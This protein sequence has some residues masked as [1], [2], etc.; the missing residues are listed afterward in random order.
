MSSRIEAPASYPVAYQAD[1][2]DDY[3]GVLVRD[4]YRWLEDPESPET[5]A[6]VAAQNELTFGLLRQVPVREAIESHLTEIWD[7]PKYGLPWRR[8]KHTFFFKNDGLQNQAVLYWQERQESEPN[9]LLDPNLL[10]EDGTVALTNLS[11]NKE[12]TLIAYGLSSSGSDWQEIRIRD[13]VSGQD[14]E[15][16]LR[17]CKFTGI[18]WKHDN[19]GFF[20]NRYREPG[21]VPPEDQYHHNRVYWHQLGTPQ[22]ADQL[23]YERLDAKELAFNPSIT[24]DG[25]Y[26]VLYVWHGTDTRNRIYYRDVESDQ[27]FVYLLDEQ[28]ARYDFITNIGHTFY[29]NSDLEAP[30]GRIIAIDIRQPEREAWQEIIPQQEDVLSFVHLINQQFVVAYLHHAHHQLKIF[31]LDGSF[32]CEIELPALGSITGLSGRQEDR[33]MFVGLSS[34]LFPNTAYHYEFERKKLTLYRQSKI[35]FDPSAYQ[36]KQVF[37]TSADGTPIPMFIT[38]KKGLPLDG[39]N[40]TLLYGYGGFYINLLPTF[41][42]SHTIWLEQGGI[43]AV[44]NLRGGG[45][46]G[47]EW[48]RAGMLEKK[49]NVFDDFIAAGE[50][51]IEN[52]YTS[53]ERLAIHGGSNGGLLVAACMLQRP[54]LFGAVICGVPVIDMLRYHKFTVGQYWVPEYGNAEENPDDFNF[55][56]AYSPL[57]NIKA[58]TT[59]PPILITSA[60]TD[61]RVVPAHAKKFAATLQRAGGRA[62]GRAGDTALTYSPNNPILLR[63][64]TKAGHGGGKPTAKIIEEQA[65]IYAFLWEVLGMAGV[66]STEFEAAQPSLRPPRSPFQG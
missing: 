20:Y 54:E 12:G 5:L 3:H 56:F 59:Y 34:F 65:D 57:H 19:T 53:S 41:S 7:Y 16:V 21:T 45:E 33:E 48:H 58:D 23:V 46:Y 11:L 10:S 55:L 28:D 64:E 22:E 42:I 39:N 30:R 26:I 8:G 62:G 35:A 60:D 40:P 36:T 14:Y 66:Y 1:V 44:P 4:P 9:V 6:W 63:V 18:A 43:F 51:L 31:N 27:P 2:V 49:Q 29:F 24:D 32:V 13:V 38:H 15:E 25:H 47:E 61:D 37:Y 52:K 17:W 50:W